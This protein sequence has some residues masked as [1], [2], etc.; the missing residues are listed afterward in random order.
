[1]NKDTGVWQKMIWLA[2]GGALGTMARYGLTGL[3]SGRSG[4]GA[5][6]WIAIKWGTLWVNSTGCFLFG[7]LWAVMERRG[8][9]SDEVRLAVFTGFLGAFTTFSTYAFES[10]ELSRSGQWGAVTV[11]VLAHNGL[12][13][14]LAWVGF[15]IGRL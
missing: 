6:D 2:L 7:L 1:M 15:S 5:S 11:T 12:G 9:L 14:L 10:F 13:L 3:V 8:S 4:G